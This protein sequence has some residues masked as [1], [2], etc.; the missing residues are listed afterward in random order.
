[1][2]TFLDKFHSQNK[3]IKTNIQIELFNIHLIQYG[4]NA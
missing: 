3:Q 1:M 2:F 4:I